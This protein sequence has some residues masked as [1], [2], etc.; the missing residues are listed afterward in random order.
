MRIVIENDKE[1]P[2]VPNAAACRQPFENEPVPLGRDLFPFDFTMQNGQ[3]PAG[4]G[5]DADLT[6]SFCAFRNGQAGVKDTLM[7]R[8]CF[9]IAPVYTY[10][11]CAGIDMTCGCGPL[12]Q[13]L[14]GTV[15][16]FRSI[17]TNVPDTG[18]AAGRPLLNLD[19]KLRPVARLLSPACALADDFMPGMF[20]H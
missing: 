11:F 19:I 8:S 20:A 2:F 12:K 5:L 3:F 15:I 14:N 17:R 9:E 7:Q 18:Y 10:Q 13:S 1:G 16:G 6:V 4:Q